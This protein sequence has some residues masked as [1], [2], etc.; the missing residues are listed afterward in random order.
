MDGPMSGLN[1]DDVEQE[2]GNFWRGLYKLEKAF[3][4]VPA[5][6]KIA[7]KVG[8]SLYSLRL[9]LFAM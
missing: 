2:V 3:E 9:V 7:G 5:A 8:M 4:S 1:P 6:K